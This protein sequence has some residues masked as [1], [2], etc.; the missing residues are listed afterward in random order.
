MA[1]R[2]LQ[3]FKSW[4]LTVTLTLDMYGMAPT[5]VMPCFFRFDTWIMISCRF[6]HLVLRYTLLNRTLN[7]FNLEHKTRECSIIGNQA[8]ELS[9]LNLSLFESIS[10]Y[11]SLHA[12]KVLYYD[13]RIEEFEH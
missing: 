7:L 8:F 11:S 9:H 2:H 13:Y 12:H 10:Y 3:T 5:P 1:P 6:S 4:T